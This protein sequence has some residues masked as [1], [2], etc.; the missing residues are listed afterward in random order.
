MA[1]KHM[2]WEEILL[3]SL[4]VGVLIYGLSWAGLVVYR[5]A[6]NEDALRALTG[7]QMKLYSLGVVGAGALLTAIV[8]Y[9]G[10]RREV[11]NFERRNIDRRRR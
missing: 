3:W 6:W 1:K 5:W 7:D 8:L 2:P 9:F 4:L 10:A 11:P